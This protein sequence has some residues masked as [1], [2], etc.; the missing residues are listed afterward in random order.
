MCLFFA[1]LTY[2]H[3]VNF[4]LNLKG[5]RPQI[6]CTS[7]HQTLFRSIISVSEQIQHNN[8]LQIGVPSIDLLLSIDLR[9]YSQKTYLL[10]K[11]SVDLLKPY[12]QSTYEKFI[13]S[14]DL[15]YHTSDRP[16]IYSYCQSTYFSKHSITLFVISNKQ[17]FILFQRP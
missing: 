2:S 1:T 6:F 5:Q 14:K 4:H 17:H 12:C 3:H 9:S 7:S 13:H 16:T 8:K 11:L 10:A 15:L